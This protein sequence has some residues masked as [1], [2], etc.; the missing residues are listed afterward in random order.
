MFGG[1]IGDPVK[2]GGIR[3]NEKSARRKHCFID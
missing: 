3:V 1:E 2:A